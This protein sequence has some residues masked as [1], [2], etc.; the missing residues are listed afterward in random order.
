MAQKINRTIIRFLLPA[1]KNSGTLQV[2]C[3]ILES[4]R[5]LSLADATFY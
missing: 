1:T 4:F 5:A 2:T 3:L